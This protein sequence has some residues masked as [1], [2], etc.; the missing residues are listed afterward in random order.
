MVAQ[1]FQLRSLFTGIRW[2]SVWLLVIA[3]LLI[4]APS[5]SGARQSELGLYSAGTDHSLLDIARTF[6]RLPL[7]FVEN[8]GQFDEHV[9]YYI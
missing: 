2:L 1:P 9:A 3:F 7:Y 5:Y 6:G 8:Q 4:L